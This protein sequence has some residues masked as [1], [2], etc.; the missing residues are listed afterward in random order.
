[1]SKHVVYKIHCNNTDDCDYIYVGSTAN[2]TVFYFFFCMS[3]FFLFLLLVLPPDIL[4][5]RKS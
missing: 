3:F 2:F 5:L 1:M 4:F